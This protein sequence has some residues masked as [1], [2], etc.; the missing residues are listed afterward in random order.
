MQS[1]KKRKHYTPRKNK[2]NLIDQKLCKPEYKSFTS[3]KHWAKNKNT[4]SGI[5]LPKIISYKKLR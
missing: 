1:G 2:N 4:Q 5:V 3:S